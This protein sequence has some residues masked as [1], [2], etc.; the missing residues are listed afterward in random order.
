MSSWKTWEGGRG[1]GKMPDCGD[2]NRVRTSQ[3]SK[4]VQERDER[5]TYVTLGNN[6][7]PL[8]GYEHGALL[9]LRQRRR[10][11]GPILL[12]DV[13]LVPGSGLGP[14]LPARKPKSAFWCSLDRKRE[15]A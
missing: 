13:A 10:E 4:R 14:V 9:L 6:L 12:P 2:H 8:G 3:A 11:R 7:S 15:I 5:R 1:D